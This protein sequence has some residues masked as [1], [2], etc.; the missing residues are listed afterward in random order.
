MDPNLT[1][2]LMP[3]AGVASNL[4]EPNAIMPMRI[5][6]S[7]IVLLLCFIGVTLRTYTRVA[8][9]KKFNL[10]DCALLFAVAGFSAF[11]VIIIIAGEHGDGKH[12]WNVSLADVADILLYVNIVEILYGPTMFCAKYAVLRQIESIFLAHRRDSRTYKAIW[13][14]IW[15]NLVFY[16]ILTFLFLFSCI[17]RE[18][19]WNP[20]IDGHCIDQ[21]NNIVATSGINVVSDVTILIVPLV[22]IAKL[23]LPL[24]TKIG[25]AAVFAI[26]ILYGTLYL[27]S[28]SYHTFA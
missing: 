13:A 8:I 15:M 18:K 7:V 14:L 2:A 19:I 21:Q 20:A 11:T 27:L 26:G 9:L 16:L 6:V 23:Q 10:E 25:S 12:Q 24:K 17:P 28:I 4:N 3:P 1:P 22:A 5:A